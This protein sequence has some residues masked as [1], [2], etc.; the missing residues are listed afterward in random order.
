MDELRDADAERKARKT[1][2]DKARK[3]AENK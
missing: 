2:E 3:T 1:F